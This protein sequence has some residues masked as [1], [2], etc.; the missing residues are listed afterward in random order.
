MK[1]FKLAFLFLA[2]LTFV[3]SCE[4]DDDGMTTVCDQSDWTGTYTGTATCD[5]TPQ[6]A[7]VTITASGTDD[8]IIVYEAR[9]TSSSTTSTTTFD[10][11]PFVGCDLDATATGT[12]VSVNLDVQLNGDELTFTE[13]T[14][15]GTDITTCVV[16]ATR[17]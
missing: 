14:T 3:T 8:I 17:N 4:D 12:G 13:I 10:P 5:G 6:E 1:T 11:L 7:T 15:V 9:D 16:A 2:L